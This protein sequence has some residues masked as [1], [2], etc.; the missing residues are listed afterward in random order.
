[1]RVLVYTDLVGSTPLNVRAGDVR[2]VELLDEHQAIIARCAAA[3]GGEIFHNTGDGFGMWFARAD[4]ALACADAIHRGLA[5]ANRRHA[6]LALHVRIGIAAGRPIP[7]DG[8]LYGLAVVRAAR[9]CARAEQDETLL[10]GEVLELD[11]VA[12]FSVEPLDRTLLKGFAEATSLY[13]ITPR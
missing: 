12:A 6:D 11:G 3:H 2:F 8:D 13:R 1:M 4:G 7:L 9:V 5:A 10:A